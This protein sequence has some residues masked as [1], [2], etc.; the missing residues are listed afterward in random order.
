MRVYLAGMKKNML[1][2]DAWERGSFRGGQAGRDKGAARHHCG[3]WYSLVQQPCRPLGTGRRKRRRATGPAS[4]WRASSTARWHAPLPL[5]NMTVSSQP[6]SS[7]VAPGRGTNCGV[8]W[9]GRSGRDLCL[10]GRGGA[11]GSLRPLS[12]LPP[13]SPP[14]HSSKHPSH[15]GLQHEALVARV[16]DRHALRVHV[17]LPPGRG[18][19]RLAGR[20]R[21][22]GGEQGAAGQ[23]GI[24]HAFAAPQPHPLRTH[25]PWRCRSG[26]HQ[27]RSGSRTRSGGGGP[28]VEGAEGAGRVSAPPSSMPRQGTEPGGPPTAP[29]G[30]PPRPPGGCPGSTH[31]QPL[32]RMARSPSASR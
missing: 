32:S 6:S 3:P 31:A 24:A 27:T 29:Q 13:Q 25:A 15:L 30:L 1:Q 9:E 8:G 10:G 5:S 16:V 20:M 26:A 28:A 12:S 4:M 23:H 11:G 14:L 19:R 17:H 21:R 7:S 2:G 22:A 18:P